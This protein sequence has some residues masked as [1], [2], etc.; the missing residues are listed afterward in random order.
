MRNTAQSLRIAVRRARLPAGFCKT[1]GRVV[2]AGKL[3][4]CPVCGKL[5]MADGSA[6]MCR[7]CFVKEQEVELE[8]TNYVRDHPKNKIPEIVEN[9]RGTEKMIKRMISEG[10]FQQVGVNLTYACEKCGAPIMTGKFCRDCMA[11]L[12]K[13]VAGAQEKLTA[14]HEREEA[15]RKGTGMRAKELHH[16]KP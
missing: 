9:T 1:K 10:R 16:K 11:T 5:F 3:R 12:Q 14:K 2:M 13:E 6:R 8:V 7:D 4:N 15:A